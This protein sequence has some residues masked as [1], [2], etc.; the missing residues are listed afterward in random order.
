MPDY[1]SP[2][3]VEEAFAR[4]VLLTDDRRT[5]NIGHQPSPPPLPG[6]SYDVRTR[7][8][9]AIGSSTGSKDEA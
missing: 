7:D 3:T 8:G 6:P 1:I 5:R 2:R 9:M 4:Y